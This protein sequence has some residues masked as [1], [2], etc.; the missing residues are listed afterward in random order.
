MFD[1]TYSKLTYKVLYSIKDIY[2]KYRQRYDWFL[3]AD[4]DTFVHVDNLRYFL[5]DKDPKSPVTYGYDYKVIVDH[6]YHSGIND[7]AIYYSK[8]HVE[9][10]GSIKNKKFKVVLVMC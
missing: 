10:S 3:K 8:N 2:K 5:R 9:I 1:D 4:L 7:K 6:G